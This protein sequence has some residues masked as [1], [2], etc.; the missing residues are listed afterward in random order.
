VGESKYLFD[1]PGGRIWRTEDGFA[2]EIGRKN[3]RRTTLLIDTDGNMV[4]ISGAP[5]NDTDISIAE[6]YL[7]VG[8]VRDEVGTLRPAEGC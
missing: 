2:V 3:K 8:R 6:T 5:I 4:D 7:R 1:E